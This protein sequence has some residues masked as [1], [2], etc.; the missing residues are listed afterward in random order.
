[1]LSLKYFYPTFLTENYTKDDRGVLLG[2]DFHPRRPPVGRAVNWPGSAVAVQL[3]TRV[4]W[5]K[6]IP[7]R[8]CSSAQGKRWKRRPNGACGSISPWMTANS[9]TLLIPMHTVVAAVVKVRA[10]KGSSSVALQIETNKGW[11]LP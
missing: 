1:M 11:E 5:G 2:S 8:G 3:T 9:A 4:G 7:Y 10:Q 6:R